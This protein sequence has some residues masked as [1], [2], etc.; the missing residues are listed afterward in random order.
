[1]ATESWENLIGQAEEGPKPIPDGI[2]NVYV[3]SAQLKSGE[4]NDMITTIFRVLDGPHAG[5]TVYNNFVFVPNKATS[6]GYFFR[7]MEALGVS[8]TQITQFAPPP[9]GLEQIAE[10]II[11]ARAQI[12]VGHHQ[13]QGKTYNNI[14]DIKP[15]AGPAGQPGPAVAPVAPAAAPAAQAPVAAQP[16]PAV[17]PAAPAQPQAPVEPQPAVQPQPAVESENVIEMPPQPPPPPF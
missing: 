9:A 17:E 1:M 13:W 4:N 8:K 2:Y 5:S 16:Q 12:K 11:G 15:A 6:L 10:A 7:H 3:E 14:A